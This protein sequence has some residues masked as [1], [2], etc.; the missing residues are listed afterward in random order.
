MI[1]QKTQEKISKLLKISPS[2]CPLG[3]A[4]VTTG[5][6]LGLIVLSYVSTFYIKAVV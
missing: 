4:V 6:L 1:K 5:S 2:F 3:L